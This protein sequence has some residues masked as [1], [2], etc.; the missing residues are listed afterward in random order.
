[1]PERQSFET[2]FASV[3][4]EISALA[5]VGVDTDGQIV[6]Y[7]LAA[8]HQTFFA[9]GPVVWIEELMVAEHARRGGL[10]SKLTAEAEAWGQSIGAAYV[11]LATRRAPEFYRA[12]GYEP[13]ATFFRKVSQ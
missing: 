12:L 11:S 7:L 9:N 1:V 10:G 4:A 8:S 5:L 2:S 6:G 3:I 13:S